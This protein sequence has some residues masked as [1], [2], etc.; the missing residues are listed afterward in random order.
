LLTIVKTFLIRIADDSHQLSWCSNPIG[1][2]T[3]RYNHCRSVF[4]Y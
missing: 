4:K 3:R 1:R 2:K